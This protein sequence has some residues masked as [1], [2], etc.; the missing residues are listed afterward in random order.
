MWSRWRKDGTYAVM[1]DAM[2]LLVAVVALVTAVIH[3]VQQ[4]MGRALLAAVI[5]VLTTLVPWSV[6]SSN[7]WLRSPIP[8]NSRVR[9]VITVVFT[10][11]TLFSLIAPL[12]VPAF[13]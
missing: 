2:F 5:A 7:P 9:F 12:F 8:L 6:R 13:R 4:D 10:V 3:A 1:V 11:S